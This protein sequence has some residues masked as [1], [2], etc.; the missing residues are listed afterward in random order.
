[1][2]APGRDIRVVIQ[3]RDDDF[4]A[5]VKLWCERTRQMKG[6]RRH[7]RAKRNLIWMSIEKIGEGLPRIHN[8]SVCFLARRISPMRVGVVMIEIL[9][10]RFG[11]HA[12]D[13]RTARPIEV[14][15]SVIGV[16]AFERGKV[17]SDLFSRGCM[18]CDCLLCYFAHLNSKE[19]KLGTETVAADEVIIAQ[20]SARSL[21][22]LSAYLSEIVTYV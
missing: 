12:R 2:R 5:P 10:H 21:S 3:F 6:E 17:L 14:G 9:N 7:V 4:I 16:A 8:G 13:L 18:C 11:H 19:F 1:K 22:H 20:F 15:H